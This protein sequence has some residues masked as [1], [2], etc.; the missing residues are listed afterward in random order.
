MAATAMALCMAVGFAL[1]YRAQNAFLRGLGWVFGEACPRSLGMIS[2]PK[3]QHYA[4][5]AL[6]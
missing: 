5:R 3:L 4:S 6:S 2:F 1:P